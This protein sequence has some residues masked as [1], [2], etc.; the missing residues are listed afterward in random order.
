MSSSVGAA[1]LRGAGC[2]RDKGGVRAGRGKDDRGRMTH[3]F[4]SGVGGPGGG[5]SLP[6]PVKPTESLRS[7]LASTN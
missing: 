1:L 7:A 3:T 4:I 5:L 6:L 2:G